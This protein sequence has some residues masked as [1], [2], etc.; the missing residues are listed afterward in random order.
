MFRLS[1]VSPRTRQRHAKRVA[2]RRSDSDV[3][4]VSTPVVAPE[5]AEARVP[6]PTPTPTLPTTA[7]VNQNTNIDV[8]L[9]SL[10]TP[11]GGN[12]NDQEEDSSQDSFQSSSDICMIV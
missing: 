8:N 5:P 2:Q 7:N 11:I 6:I 4:Q 9:D 12:H 10:R 1:K 3:T